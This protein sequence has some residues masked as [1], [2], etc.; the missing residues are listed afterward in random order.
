[1]EES[2]YSSDNSENTADP[3]ATILAHMSAKLEEF[4]R[5]EK[6]LKEVTNNFTGE[7][8][9][10]KTELVN[11]AEARKQ[12]GVKLTKLQSSLKVVSEDI[13]SN[14]EVQIR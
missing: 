7:L 11:M 6:K 13:A 2:K 12:G 3:L 9:Y 4:S 8:D 5:L 1:M 10:L 14:V